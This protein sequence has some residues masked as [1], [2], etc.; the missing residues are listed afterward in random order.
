MQDQGF[1]VFGRLS[2]NSIEQVNPSSAKSFLTTASGNPF[3]I[4]VVP[5]PTVTLETILGPPRSC[6]IIK[7]FEAAWKYFFVCSIGIA[8]AFVGIL[9]IV[10]AGQ[11][12]NNPDIN[13]S[14]LMLGVPLMEPLWL[15]I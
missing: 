14:S 5:N 11:E 7:S 13:I 6:Q 4:I 9:F 10:I 15:K 3:S 8:L 2:T 1:Q 12:I